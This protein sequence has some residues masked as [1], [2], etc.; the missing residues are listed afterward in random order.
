M[1]TA[2]ALALACSS[3]SARA[4]DTAT[5]DAEARFAE[6][7]SRVKKQDYEGARLSFAQAYTVL[8]RPLILWNLALSEE[9]SGHPIDALTHFRKVAQDAP[10]EADRAS[11]RKHIDS[12]QAKTSRVDIEAPSGTTFTLDGSDVA[13]TAPLGDPVD[14]IPGHHV[15]VAKLAIS[16]KT[17]EVDTLA[18]QIAH[19]TFAA[20]PP[21]IAAAPAPA[22]SVPVEPQ[23][24]PY[25]PPEPTQHPF[26]TARTITAASLAGLAVAATGVAIGF[27]VASQNH[28]STA[29][30]DKGALGQSGCAAPTGNAAQCSALNDAVNSQNRDANLSNAL[31]FTGGA[32]AVGAIVSWFFWPKPKDSTAPT[33][34]IMPT[35]SP[36]SV[37]VG[38]GGRF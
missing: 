16:T 7:L 9:K 28:K 4:D 24:V 38:A 3:S 8:H 31:Y 20:D 2:G 36:G 13:G 5:R 33:A 19:V 10:S 26:W 37:A 14:V 32:L 15:I 27:G 11:A 1:M 34:W 25:T 6:G 21:A 22:A 17:S 30:D 29:D 18:G 35:V 23:P 12:L